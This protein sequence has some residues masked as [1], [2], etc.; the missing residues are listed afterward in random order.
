MQVADLSHAVYR[1]TAHTDL[2]LRS[3]SEHHPGH[4][5]GLFYPLS[6]TALM[7]W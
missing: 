1:K 5:K 3:D 6:C 2:Y 4:A 7:L